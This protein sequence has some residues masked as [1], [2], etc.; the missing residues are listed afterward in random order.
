MNYLTCV[1]LNEHLCHLLHKYNIPLPLNQLSIAHLSYYD[2]NNLIPDRS[3]M[4]IR[5]KCCAGVT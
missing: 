1:C 2:N 5:V 4:M 3:I